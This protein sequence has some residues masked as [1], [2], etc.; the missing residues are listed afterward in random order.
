MI[1]SDEAQAKFSEYHNAQGSYDEVYIDGSKIKEKVEAAA[2][3]NR[4]FQNDETT[5]HQRSKKL[6][7]NNM[8]FAAEATAI[9]WTIIST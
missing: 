6:P 3:I 5:C 4:H 7:N 1:T 9:T 2:V 8:I